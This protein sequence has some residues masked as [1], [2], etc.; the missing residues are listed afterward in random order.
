MEAPTASHFFL[1]GIFVPKKGWFNQGLYLVRDYVVFLLY[2]VKKYELGLSEK[3]AMT[4][5]NLKHGR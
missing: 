2:V 4:E 3:V 5:D 1:L